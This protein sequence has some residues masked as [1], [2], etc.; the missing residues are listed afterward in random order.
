MTVASMSE[1]IVPFPDRPATDPIPSPI[2]SVTW[3]PNA[4]TLIVP[5]MGPT[6]AGKSTFLD[7][8]RRKNDPRIGL[9]EVGKA[10]RLKY[11]ADYFKGQAAPAHTQEEATSMCQS[12]IDQYLREQ[13]Y[14]IL[15]DG[16]PRH[17]DQ[18]ALFSEHY[19][20]HPR[21]AVWYVWLHA[22]REVR[23]QRAQASRT[24]A[25]LD[26][27]LSRLDGDIVSMYDVLMHILT[28]PNKMIS[29]V[30]TE[31]S[32]E[33]TPFRSLKEIAN[34]LLGLVGLSEIE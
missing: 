31:S 33:E 32:P 24:G 34:E 5:V 16:Q 4:H 19:N 18:V 27:A 10:L 26:L 14:L 28:L 29:L 3:P 12:L 2:P 23:T 30:N 8:F 9:V 6:C 15:V 7:L 1:R 21:A 11:G 13:R 22:S 20:Q 25:S 17:M